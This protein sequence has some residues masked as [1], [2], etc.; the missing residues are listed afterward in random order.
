MG[1]PAV[2]VAGLRRGVRRC[3]GLSLGVGLLC[4][5]A[6]PR[7]VEPCHGALVEA[8]EPIGWRAWPE[9]SGRDDIG[10]RLGAFVLTG[11]SMMP[12]Y[13]LGWN[14]SQLYDPQICKSSSIG[15]DAWFERGPEPVYSRSPAEL[16]LRQGG[17]QTFVVSA[18]AWSEQAPAERQSFVVAFSRE[19]GWRPSFVSSNAMWLS[20]ALTTSLLGSLWGW[21]WGRRAWRRFE[22]AASDVAFDLRQGDAALSRLK[23]AFR[24]AL[25]ALGVAGFIWL[26]A[27]WLVVS[28]GFAI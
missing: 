9:T 17:D 21:L 19:R 2:V 27:W 6:G 15:L 14:D 11:R 26:R 12:K 18:A 10:N 7:V 8:P 23:W 25:T 5:V 16:H 24:L 3:A 20:L 4:V 28:R 13:G 1:E 22:Q